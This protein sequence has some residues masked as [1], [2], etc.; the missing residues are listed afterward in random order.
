MCGCVGVWVCV[1]ASTHTHTHTHTYTHVCRYMRIHGKRA[2]FNGRIF[3]IVNGR[4]FRITTRHVIKEAHEGKEGVSV[5]GM[6]K[7]VNFLRPDG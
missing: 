6:L 3:T 5:A 2:C 7:A 1:H 4:I